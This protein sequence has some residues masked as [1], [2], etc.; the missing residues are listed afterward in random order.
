[1]PSRARDVSVAELGKLIDELCKYAVW[2]RN[3]SYLREAEGIAA[4]LTGDL[5][6]LDSV[7]ADAKA[8]LGLAANPSDPVSERERIEGQVCD[9]ILAHASCLCRDTSVNVRLNAIVCRLAL[10]NA[11]LGV[12]YDDIPPEVMGEYADV[13][14]EQ[15][16]A[17][18]RALS[19][20][21]PQT[22][23]D[24][25]LDY[26]AAHPDPAS[27]VEAYRRVAAS[28]AFA[29]FVAR[30]DGWNEYADRAHPWRQ[31]LERQ[32]LPL[33]RRLME[34][35]GRDPSSDPSAAWELMCSC[36]C[37]RVTSVALD[38]D[39]V[40]TSPFTLP[41]IPSDWERR[42]TFN[43]LSRPDRVELYAPD[44]KLLLA[45]RPRE[46]DIPPAS[47]GEVAKAAMSL[48]SAGDGF[49]WREDD[50]ERLSDQIA[51]V[52]SG[53]EARRCVPTHLTVI[54]GTVSGHVHA[55]E[56]R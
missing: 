54:E 29:D 34:L 48:L 3:G 40:C 49:G 19:A 52:E 26:A 13:L 51:S 37:D 23:R 12:T 10:A 50:A 43:W 14:V 31:A 42:G 4:E 9:A 25:A 8:S 28:D 47:P 7:V 11:V 45:V 6:G 17:T 22:A 18:I 16:D 5:S 44:S 32:V 39:G 15:S 2:T 56:Q 20:I 46:G 21:A 1:M 24:M 33:R 38:Y 36:A 30:G 27:D 55:A 35:D 53:R 41:P